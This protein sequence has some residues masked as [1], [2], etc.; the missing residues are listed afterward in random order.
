MF[1]QISM[2]AHLIVYDYE[3][4]NP[5]TDGLTSLSSSLTTRVICFK[6]ERGTRSES[7]I[8]KAA[9]DLGPLLSLLLN[10]LLVRSL[11]CQH[12]FNARIP[13]NFICEVRVV[14]L[15]CQYLK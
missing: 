6:T 14:V 5:F 4:S 8:R 10:S 9:T 2:T 7:L 1:P 3:I 15:L 13:K 12:T 11:V